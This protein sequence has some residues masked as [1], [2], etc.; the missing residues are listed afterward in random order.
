MF[1]CSGLLYIH[2][3]TVSLLVRLTPLL[4]LTTEHVFLFHRRAGYSAGKIAENLLFRTENRSRSLTLG[5][6]ISSLHSL[7]DY[8]DTHHNAYHS[9]RVPSMSTLGVLF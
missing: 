7:T 6:L 2:E 1:H 9:S 8:R 3:N 4:F 5:L